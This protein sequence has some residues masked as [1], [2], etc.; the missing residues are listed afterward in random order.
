MSKTIIQ[1]HPFDIAREAEKLVLVFKKAYS[2]SYSDRVKLVW[3][4]PK[5]KM[6][7]E[8]RIMLDEGR[9]PKSSR[10]LF[11]VDY[12]EALKFEVTV[13]KD[14]KG[15]HLATLYLTKPRAEIERE[16]RELATL[17]TE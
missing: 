8:L 2:P 15:F 3:M 11:G 6:E 17:P 13:T 10:I 12:N 9:L 4:G 5:S 14:K 16:L 1:R 7:K